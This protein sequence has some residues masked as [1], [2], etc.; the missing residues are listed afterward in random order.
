MPYSALWRDLSILA[1]NSREI[2]ELSPQITRNDRAHIIL[3]S[4]GV[5]CLTTEYYKIAHHKLSRDE[6]PILTASQ[7]MRLSG[8]LDENGLKASSGLG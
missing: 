4:S 5:L 3:N 7:N 1:L 8:L 6:G 2:L